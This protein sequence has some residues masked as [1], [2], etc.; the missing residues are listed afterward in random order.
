MKKAVLFSA[1]GVLAASGSIARA[2]EVGRVL[3]ASPV[4]QQVQVPRQVCSNQ[5]VGGQPNSGAGAVVGGLAGGAIG[6]SGGGGG[7][8]A[9]ATVLGVVGGALLGNSVESANNQPR[10]IQR[11]TTQTFLENRTVAY[12]VRYEYAGREHSVQMPY[13]PGPTIRLQVTPVADNAPAQSQQGGVIVA[14]PVQ[15]NG[16]TPIPPVYPGDTQAQPAYPAN[17]G[18]QVYPA[19][20]QAQPMPQSVYQ[21]AT[22]S[23]LQSPDGY[24]PSE[25]VTST[26]YYPAAYPYYPSYGYYPYYGSY[27]PAFPV[28]LSLG[29]GFSNWG[30]GGGHGWNG[31]GH[32][33]GFR[34]HGGGFRGH[35]GGGGRR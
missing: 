21:T 5:V 20:G 13:D 32:G 25:T 24:P 11:C 26:T 18:Q 1:M 2:D 17:Q 22:P 12:N 35:G 29:F 33:S 6:N 30:W 4:I 31:G 7:G 9:A 8:R 16:N 28:A 14:P 34:G 23:Y 27:Y 19:A 3:E 15:G 10:N